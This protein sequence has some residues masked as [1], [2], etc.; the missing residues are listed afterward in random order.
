MS[1]LITNYLGEGAASARPAT[2][3]ITPGAT[4]FYYATDTGA[5]SFWNGSAWSAVTGTGDNTREFALWIVTSPL[6]SNEVLAGLTPPAGET[7]TFPANLSTSAGLK[8]SGGTNPGSTYTMNLARN[9]T[10]V[11]SIVISTSGGV[12]FSTVG[13]A[14]FILTGGSDTLQVIGPASADTALGYAFNLKCT[15]A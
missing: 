1:G 4:A 6:N 14:P 13:G 5:L 12:T 2:P 15:W 7:W 8:L 9:G 10:S 3:S 11:G